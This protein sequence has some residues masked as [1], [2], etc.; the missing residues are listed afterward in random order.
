M[1]YILSVANR[2]KLQPQRKITKK[3]YSPEERKER[4]GSG[5]ELLAGLGEGTAVLTPPPNNPTCRLGGWREPAVPASPPELCILFHYSKREGCFKYPWSWSHTAGFVALLTRELSGADVHTVAVGMQ[6]SLERSAGSPS[7][8][9]SSDPCRAA[10]HLETPRSISSR[11]QGDFVKRCFF[12][13]T[14]S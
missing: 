14:E 10:D 4:A 12:C 8:V 5:T 2:E 9:D 1:F 7:R 3:G 11:K 6:A 13:H